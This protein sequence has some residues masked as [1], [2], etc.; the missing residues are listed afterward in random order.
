MEPRKI[1]IID[2]DSGEMRAKG[3]AARPDGRGAGHDREREREERGGAG[4]QGRG[5]VVN[6]RRFW[7]LS[8]EELEREEERPRLPSFVEKL[9]QELEQRDTQLREYIKAYKKEVGEGLERTKGRLQ[10]EAAAELERTRGAMTEPMLDVL[11]AMERSLLA[12]GSASV[13]PESL[14][15][16]MRMV[17]QLMVSKLQSMGLQR[18][19]TVGQPFDP[20]MH[21]ALAVA[22]VKDPAQHNVVLHELKPGFTMGERVVRPAQVQVGKHT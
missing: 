20:R 7:N 13:N 9:Q 3:S 14:L 22:A 18:I 8:D 15:E 2:E 5:F 16:G 17:H 6:D 12:A 11:D 21:E 19:E 10:R 4:D 1:E